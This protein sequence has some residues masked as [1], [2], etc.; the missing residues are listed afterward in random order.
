[1]VKFFLA[2]QKPAPKPVLKNAF[3]V[4]MSNEQLLPEAILSPKNNFDRLY[5]S[6]IDLMKENKLGWSRSLLTSTGCKFTK[7]LTSALWHVTCHHQFFKDRSAA[8]PDIF[9]KFSNMNDYAKKKKSKPRLQSSSLK[10]YIEELSAFLVQPWFNR[11]SFKFFNVACNQLVE[12]LK[13]VYDF[14]TEQNEK[15][16]EQHVSNT[17]IRHISENTS[18]CIRPAVA[19][20]SPKYTSLSEFIEPMKLYE[21]LHLAEFEPKERYERRHWSDKLSLKFPIAIMKRH[22]GGRLGNISIIWKVNTAD[23]SHDTK[24]AQATLTVTQELPTYHTRQM[25]KDFVQ[26]YG[27]IV[28]ASKTALIDIYKN[29]TGICTNFPSLYQVSRQL[30]E[31]NLIL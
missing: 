21:P 14:L 25:R 24:M 4:L 26:K 5:N 23:E 16:K 29:A 11:Q 20:T 7:C 6:L 28:K 12:S 10:T 22:Y 2:L 1:M 3:S 19:V 13:K 30:L 9:A 27:H 18:I 31:H 15:Q 8:I 17:E